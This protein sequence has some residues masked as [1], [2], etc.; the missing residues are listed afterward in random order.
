MDI[1]N[2]NELNLFEALPQHNTILNW[3][4]ETDP[5]VKQAILTLQSKLTKKQ[6]EKCQKGKKF[7]SETEK[8]E[9]SFNFYDNEEDDNELELEYDTEEGDYMLDINPFKQEDL[10]DIAQDDEFDAGVDNM[11]DVAFCVGVDIATISLTNYNDDTE[12]EYELTLH[13]INGEVY[14]KLE[15][16][17]SGENH[18][19]IIEEQPKEY[20][21]SAVELE[22]YFYQNTK[23]L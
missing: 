7:E 5:D 10:D 14:M 3:F 4:A 15:K 20:R 23:S 22:A 11:I 18:D 13:K 9:V 8:A 17:M 12:I 21:I 2:N 16:S 6:L 1:K 19:K